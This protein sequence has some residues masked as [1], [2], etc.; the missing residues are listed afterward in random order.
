MFTKGERTL[1]P[2]ENIGGGGEFFLPSS[3]FL[4]SGFRSYFPDQTREEVRVAVNKYR[5]RTVIPKLAD[6][7]AETILYMEQVRGLDRLHSIIY[8][9]AELG[10]DLL[11]GIT[12]VPTT[13]VRKVLATIPETELLSAARKTGNP[14]KAAQLVDDIKRGGSGS[15]TSKKTGSGSIADDLDNGKVGTTCISA[16]PTAGFIAVASDVPTMEF[17]SGKEVLVAALPAD[18]VALAA[19]CKV[20]VEEFQAYESPFDGTRK[21]PNGRAVRP[22]DSETVLGWGKEKG[23]F[24]KTN[25]RSPKGNT[26]VYQALVDIPNTP[27]KKSNYYYLDNFHGNLAPEIEV[28]DKTGKKHLG[29][30]DIEGKKWKKPSDKTKKPIK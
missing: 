21:D 29:T 17:S 26:S 28:F 15:R 6:K 1:L 5:Y 25:L 16:S 8:L 18:V 20:T 30:M 7:A 10:L 9:M 19:K 27:I 24:T 3:D 13:N 23:I 4:S 2:T 14:A 12:D 22:L 11:L